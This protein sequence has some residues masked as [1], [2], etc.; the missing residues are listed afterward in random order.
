MLAH[1][2]SVSEVCVLI[3]AWIELYLS[4][5]EKNGI[6]N[7]YPEGMSRYSSLVC[8]IPD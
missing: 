5:D 2:V 3:L 8:T 7:L 4:T 1:K 6:R